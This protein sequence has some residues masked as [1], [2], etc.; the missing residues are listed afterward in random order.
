MFAADPRGRAR[1]QAARCTDIPE[2][3]S[4]LDGWCQTERK[5]GSALLLALPAAWRGGTRSWERASKI[6]STATRFGGPVTRWVVLVCEMTSPWY[7]GGAGVRVA[8]V[9]ALQHHKA[10]SASPSRRFSN[11]IILTKTGATAHISV[12]IS[13]WGHISAMGGWFCSPDRLG[14]DPGVR[15]RKPV[16]LL[17]ACVQQRCNICACP[18]GK[19]QEVWQC[20][21]NKVCGCPGVYVSVLMGICRLQICRDNV[22]IS[23]VYSTEKTPARISLHFKPKAS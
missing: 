13:R 21:V 19:R 1:S 23:C 3:H 18:G 9:S 12:E 22:N 4:P 20:S 6:R 8:A 14:W 11:N 2:P 15:C 5:R 17:S 16:V 7:W 10:S